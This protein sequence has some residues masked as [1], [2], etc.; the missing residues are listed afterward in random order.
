MTMSLGS[1]VTIRAV[2]LL[3]LSVGIIFIPAGSWR[4]WRGWAFLA[5]Y[6]LPGLFAFVYFLRYDKQLVER[7]LRHREPVREQRLL[8]RGGF[9]MFLV[10]FV[11]PGF[12]YRLGWSRQLLGEVPVWLTAISLAL[13]TSGFLFVFWT[14]KVNSY[15]GRTIQVEAGQTVISTGPY[16]WVRHPMYTGSVVVWLSTSLALGSWVALPAFILLIPFYVVRLLNEEKV[17]LAEL[18]GYSEYCAKTRF[19]LIPLVW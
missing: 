13:V 14:L 4:F 16:A 3:L 11:L 9:L 19:H 18:P 12:D 8:I 17:L 10:A 6:F 5:A 7:R 1:R 15:A 2:I